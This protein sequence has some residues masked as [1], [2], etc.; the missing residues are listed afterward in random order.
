M[1]ALDLNDQELATDC[2]KKLH[3]EARA[4]EVQVE[5]SRSAPRVESAR[6]HSFNHLETTSLSSHIGIEVDLRPYSEFPKSVRVGRLVGRAPP[7]QQPA[8]VTHN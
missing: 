8:L 3:R 4:E 7:L 5:H 6:F 2:I 1:A